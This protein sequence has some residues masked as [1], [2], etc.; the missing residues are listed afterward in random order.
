VTAYTSDVQ[1][2]RAARSSRDQVADLVRRYPNVSDK[3]RREILM[4]MKEGRHLDI[5]LLTA[6]DNLRPR[7]DAF[8]ADHRRHFRIG[9]LDVARVLAVIAA[10]VLVCWLLW[11]LVRPASI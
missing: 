11:E 6:N 3:D 7:L 2:V 1:Q 5:G 9:V 10:A 8:M 4:F